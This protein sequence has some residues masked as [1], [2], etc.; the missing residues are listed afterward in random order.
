MP[1]QAATRATHYLYIGAIVALLGVGLGIRTWGVLIDP[2]DLWGDEAWWATLLES[3]SLLD[4]GFR[5]IGYMWICRQLLDLGSPEVMLRLPSWLAGFAALLFIYKS[6]D[7]TFRSRAAVL[8]VLLLA[9]VN[10]YLVV[11]AKEFKIGRAHV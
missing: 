9:A 10:P 6:A 1:I 8:F 2:L 3:R 5:P 4:L 11:F 7:L